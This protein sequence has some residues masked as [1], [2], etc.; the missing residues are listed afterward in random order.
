MR[1]NKPLVFCVLGLAQSKGQV[2]ESLFGCRPRQRIFLSSLASG[3]TCGPTPPIQ[4][5]RR[6]KWATRVDLV[7][8]WVELY[9]HSPRHM[10]LESAPYTSQSK[11]LPLNWVSRYVQFSIFHSL[12]TGNV[13]LGDHYPNL[14]PPPTMPNS[15]PDDRC[16]RNFIRTSQPIT[17]KLVYNH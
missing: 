5:I 8:C 12:Q 3:P 11:R 13:G 14:P 2:K 1:R 6:P 4:W 7:Y 10:L 9:L 17:V 16:S 15:E